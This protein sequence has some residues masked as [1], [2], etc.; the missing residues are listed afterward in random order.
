M[1]KPIL[2]LIVIL[3]ILSALVIFAEYKWY[4]VAQLL[5]RIGVLAVGLLPGILLALITLIP[6]IRKRARSDLA[7]RV[8]MLLVIM[9]LSAA[10]V[11]SVTRWLEAQFCYLDL[12]LVPMVP[13]PD[14]AS[15]SGREFHTFVIMYEEYREVIDRETWIRAMVPPFLRRQCYTTKEYICVFV[16]QFPKNRVP[17]TWNRYL[18]VLAIAL[19]FSLP[20]GA[21]A[22]YLTRRKRPQE[23]VI[24]G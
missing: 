10:L 21:F 1:K 17:M 18:L 13:D 20:G 22:G 15:L 19:G 24:E 8:V 3:A 7:G 11:F 9:M 14:Y 4:M 5:F 6:A 23:V 16:D 12:I 2:V